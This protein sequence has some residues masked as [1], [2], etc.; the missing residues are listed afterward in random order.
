MN[1]ASATEPLPS[2]LVP[3]P[4]AKKQFNN[5][6]VAEAKWNLCVLRAKEAKEAYK[7]AKGEWR[8][9]MKE[10]SSL[11][12]NMYKSAS[13]RRKCKMGEDEA[14]EAKATQA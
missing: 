6:V 12:D 3:P 1:M 4:S 7:V 2:Q 5:L 13:K 10:E 11:E 8:K 9:L 14:A